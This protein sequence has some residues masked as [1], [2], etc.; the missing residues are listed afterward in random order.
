M[1]A[2]P[3]RGNGDIDLVEGDIRDEELLQSTFE[4]YADRRD[5]IIAVIHLAGVKDVGEG[6]EKPELWVCN[7]MSDTINGIGLY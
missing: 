1:V 6:E 5:P 4:Q 7:L 2:I 3:D